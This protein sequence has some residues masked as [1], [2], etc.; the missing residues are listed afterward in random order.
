MLDLSLC[1][2][3]PPVM[4]NQRLPPTRLKIAQIL[5]YVGLLGVAG[6]LVL[7]HKE[8]LLGGMSLALTGAV[9]GMHRL[10]CPQC[11]K[12]QTSVCVE[13]EHCQSCGS[14]LF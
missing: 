13:I 9:L 8:L 3:L 2:I 1:H 6:E 4:P 12:K 7:G 11:G 14:A 10:T 5:L